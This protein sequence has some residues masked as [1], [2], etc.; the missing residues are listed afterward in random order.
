MKMNQF[1]VHMYIGPNSLVSNVTFKFNKGVQMMTFQKIRCK[2]FLSYSS[3]MPTTC[4]WPIY[5]NVKQKL[6]NLKFNIKKNTL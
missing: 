6:L 5:E 1:F 2:D 3:I 4:S